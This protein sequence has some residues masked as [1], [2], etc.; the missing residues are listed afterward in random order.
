MTQ[1]LEKTYNS[2]NRLLSIVIGVLLLSVGGLWLYQSRADLAQ[3]RDKMRQY[4]LVDSGD[5]ATLGYGAMTD[6]H[7]ADFFRT[8][9]AEFPR[10]SSYWNE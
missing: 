1:D 4:G 7:W 3:A 9:G 2:W 10:R 6:R 5:V 8:V